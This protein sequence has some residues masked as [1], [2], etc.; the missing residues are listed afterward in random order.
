MKK[1][2]DLNVL[3][4]YG[5]IFPL[6]MTQQ[7]RYNNRHRIHN[8]DLAQHSFMVAYNILKIGYNYSKIP[9]AEIYKACS[10]AIVHDCPE[11][12]T[13]DIP[14][15]CKTKHPEL[16]SM[17]A[18]IEQEFITEEMPELETLYNEYAEGSSLAFTLVELGD[19]ISVLQYVN[20]ELIHGNK[21]EDMQIIK[22]EVSLR[23]VKL[24]EKLDKAVKEIK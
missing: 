6:I 16:R 5:D 11:M 7:V 19:A 8:E 4:L 18:D 9:R 17:L 2:R 21:H 12:F 13:S 14:H 15:D 3:D 1:L 24:F 22:N 23:I 20:R 10:M